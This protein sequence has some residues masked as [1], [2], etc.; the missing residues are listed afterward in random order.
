MRMCRFD[1]RILPTH[2]IEPHTPVAFPGPWL[3]RTPVPATGR[4]G[5]GGLAKAS[6]RER[7]TRHCRRCDENAPNRNGVKSDACARLYECT[8]VRARALDGGGRRR[9][10]AF[11]CR[12]RQ[13][14]SRRFRPEPHTKS[15]GFIV[16]NGGDVLDAAIVMDGGA[17]APLALPVAMPVQATPQLS[18]TVWS[19]CAARRRAV[20]TSNTCRRYVASLR[21]SAGIIGAPRRRA[22]APYHGVQ[23]RHAARNAALVDRHARDIISQF[24]GRGAAVSQCATQSA[25]GRKRARLSSKF[26]VAGRAR[27]AH[28]RNQKPALATMTSGGQGAEHRTCSAGTQIASVACMHC[29]HAGSPRNDPRLQLPRRHR[30]RRRIPRA[31]VAANSGSWDTESPRN[32]I[33]R[34]ARRRPSHWS[35]L[36]NSRM[37]TPITA[38]ARA[39]W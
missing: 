31:F 27:L 5:G 28:E 30:C 9:T 7:C 39:R 26:K 14:G 20:R 38:V 12:R 21:A 29:A 11:H 18:A 37:V 10:A 19:T 16:P 6:P 24:T 1:G 3:P 23:P 35:T 2:F 34:S 32:K 22:S 4:L 13:G 36:Q 33:S 17:A 15:D 25:S 8:D